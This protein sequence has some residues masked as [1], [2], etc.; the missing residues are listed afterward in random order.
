[1]LPRPRPPATSS[2]SSGDGTGF[3]QVEGADLYF[4]YGPGETGGFNFQDF[5][6]LASMTHNNASNALT[7]SA[8]SATSIATGFKANNGVISVALPGDGSDRYTLLE[9]FRDQGKRTGLVTTSSMT[10]ATP[11][12]FG[13]HDPSRSNSSNIANDYFN[14]TRPN[15]LFGGGASGFDRDG[16][17]DRRILRRQQPH[18]AQRPQR[19]RYKSRRRRL[20]QRRVRLRV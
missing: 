16:R 7:D 13:A 6:N 9:Y 8:A 5:S 1:M 12:G 20:R 17:D 19:R 4:N 18:A 15:V 11:A 2:S 3:E 14:Q 10:D